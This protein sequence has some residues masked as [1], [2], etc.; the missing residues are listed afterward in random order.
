MAAGQLG[1]MRRP[2]GQPLLICRGARLETFDEH[3][4]EQPVEAAAARVGL[5]TVRE[6]SRAVCE[7]TAAD[8]LKFGVPADTEPAGGGAS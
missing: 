7:R 5:A 6:G 1:G 8:L 4:A 3:A 2:A